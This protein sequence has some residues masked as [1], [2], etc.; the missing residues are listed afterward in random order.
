MF[1]DG[2]NLEFFEYKGITVSSRLFQN[3]H[4]QLVRSSIITGAVNMSMH[5]KSSIITLSIVHDH[6]QNRYRQDG[7]S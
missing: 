7:E 1:F 2:R 6:D 4:F 3:I 5:A